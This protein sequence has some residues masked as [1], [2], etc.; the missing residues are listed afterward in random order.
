MMAQRNM[1]ARQDDMPLQQA[2]TM[3]PRRW[4]GNNPSVTMGTG[5]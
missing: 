5:R 2:G 4:S 1:D 3:Y